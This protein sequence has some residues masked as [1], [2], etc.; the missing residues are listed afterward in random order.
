MSFSLSLSASQLDPLSISLSFS[1]SLPLL[2]PTST[3]FL[4]FCFL[5]RKS[6]GQ[7]SIDH[8]CCHIVV[9]IEACFDQSGV[10]LKELYHSNTEQFVV[11]SYSP[12]PN[13]M[14]TLPD[15]T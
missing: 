11:S 7:R 10:K 3:L 1:L 6:F 15:V 14:S 13:L 2:A 5:S 8:H 12:T 9:V 4:S